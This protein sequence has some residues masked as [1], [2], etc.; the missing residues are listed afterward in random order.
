MR[1]IGFGLVGGI[2]VAIGALLVAAWPVKG[3]PVAAFFPAGSSGRDIAGAVVRAGGDLIQ[4][5][6]GAAV[7]ISHGADHGYPTALYR[8]GAWLVVDAGFSKLCA[9]IAGRSGR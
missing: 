6:A 5:D 2:I 3:R 9:G 8:M 1:E 7:A 4:I